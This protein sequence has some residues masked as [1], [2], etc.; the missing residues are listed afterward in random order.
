M[1]V[2]AGVATPEAAG[3]GWTW[4]EVAQA[5]AVGVL[6]PVALL[7]TVMALVVLKRHLQVRFRMAGGKGCE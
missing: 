1:A 3:G 4:G 7:V 2:P 5:G 6:G